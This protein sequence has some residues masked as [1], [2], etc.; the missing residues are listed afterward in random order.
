MTEHVTPPLG[1][2]YS[3][4]DAAAY[5]GISIYQLRRLVYAKKITHVRF[6]QP[7]IYERWLEEYREA[8][9][10]RRDEP[11]PVALAGARA[12]GGTDLEGVNRFP[13]RQATR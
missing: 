11:R 8:Q 5:L 10:V 7:G 13:G 3:F 1:R 9:T 4:R 6:G 12:A 2:L